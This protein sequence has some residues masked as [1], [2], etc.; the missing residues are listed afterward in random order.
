[1]IT[2]P[3]RAHEP[4]LQPLPDCLAPTG[5]DRAALPDLRMPRAGE[6]VIL[7]DEHVYWIAARLAAS[8]NTRRPLVLRAA[9]LR[10]GTTCSARARPA[11]TPPGT[12]TA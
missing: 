10:A 7:H 12:T 9:P 6:H 5:T 4:G 11:P 1:M 2:A 8:P 3:H